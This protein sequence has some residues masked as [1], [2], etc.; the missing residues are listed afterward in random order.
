MGSVY[1]DLSR[2]GLAFGFGGLALLEAAGGLQVLVQ[3]PFDLPVDTAELISRPL[4]QG[5][6]G[7]FIDAQNK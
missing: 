4:L 3:D 5:L 1:R 7:V 2:L 6:I